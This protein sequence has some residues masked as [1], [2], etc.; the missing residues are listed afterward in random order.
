MPQ[1]SISTSH[2]AANR[3]APR[4]M[5]VCGDTVVRPR[6]AFSLAEL[7]IAMAILGLGMVV[8]AAMFPIAWDKARDSS[9]HTAYI[10]TLSAA[11]ANVRLLTHL[12]SAD[13][14]THFLGDADEDPYVG[15]APRDPWVHALDIENL[16]TVPWPSVLNPGPPIVADFMASGVGLPSPPDPDSF[17]DTFVKQMVPPPY[18]AFDREAK[19]AVQDRVYPPLPKPPA[20]AAG[21]M[22]PEIKHWQDE[23]N[24]RRFCWSV[25]YKQDFNPHDPPTTST[26]PRSMILYLVTLRRGQDTHRYARQNP[27]V[28]G[29]GELVPAYRDPDPLVV[30]GLNAPGDYFEPAAHGPTEDVVFPVPW[31]IQIDLAMPVVPPTPPTGVPT[32]AYANKNGETNRLV[33]EMLPEGAWMIDEINGLVYRVASRQILPT[34]PDQ[35]ILTLDQ[36]VLFADVDDNGDDTIQPEE[37]IRTV[38][39]FPPPVEKRP[40]GTAPLQFN[41]PQPVVGIELRKIVVSD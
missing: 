28:A 8:V 25:L 5:P 11:E 15:G 31:R 3:P 35:A 14:R 29:G 27:G 30:G 2:P 26:G 9:D 22:T 23:L 32:E 34:D 21:A 12:R 33:T 6:P 41:G 38:W 40:N 37:L 10:A 1:T 19:I 20:G 7:M 24:E 17:H 36:E 18:I 13:T 39:V 4:Q 16:S